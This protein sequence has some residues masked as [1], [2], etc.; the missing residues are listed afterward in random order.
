MLIDRCAAARFTAVARS[1]AS[2]IAAGTAA[3]RIAHRRSAC[4][5][6][7]AGV[8]KTAVRA[9]QRCGIASGLLIR[10]A[11]ELACSSDRPAIAADDR[12][13]APVGIGPG[14]LATA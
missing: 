12:I 8:R 2:D 13:V 9:S 1:P 3:D 7:S 5:R 4:A 11:G 14:N 6:C 10:H